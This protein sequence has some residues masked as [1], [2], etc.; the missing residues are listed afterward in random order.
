MTATFDDIRMCQPTR[1]N[2]RMLHQVFFFVGVAFF[3]R[4]NGAD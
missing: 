1:S 4:K 2:A 3:P